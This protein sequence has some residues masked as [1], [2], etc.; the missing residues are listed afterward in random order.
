MNKLF[1]LSGA[2]LL[3][4]LMSAPAEAGNFKTYRNADYERPY[5]SWTEENRTT[6]RTTHGKLDRPEHVMR[7]PEHYE[8]LPYV[9]NWDAQHKHPQQWQGQDWDTSMWNKHWT[10]DSA[11]KKLFEGRV[12]KRQYMR[13][14]TVPVLELGP[15]FYQLSDLDQRRTLKLLADTTGIFGKGFGMVELRDWNTRDVVGS[16]TPQGMYLN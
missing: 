14:S 12:F 7:R 1:L 11:V 13:S 2:C 8:F 10:P 3:A 16:Y 6:G 15:I 9:S 5:T 4:A